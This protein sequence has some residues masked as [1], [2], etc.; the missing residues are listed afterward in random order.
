LALI[1]ADQD[2]Y[3]L[4]QVNVEQ[5]LK[6][7][8]RAGD[9]DGVSRCRNCRDAL[10]QAQRW[11]QRSKALDSMIEENRRKSSTNVGI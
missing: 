5:A 6:L 11:K 9:Q 7:Y 10:V 4:A 3:E 2:E 8:E 1:R